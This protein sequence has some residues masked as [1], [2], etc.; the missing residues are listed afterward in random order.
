M[1]NYCPVFRILSER[2]QLQLVG[3]LVNA[4]NSSILLV[5]MALSA[6]AMKI[7]GAQLRQ[8]RGCSVALSLAFMNEF[9]TTASFMERLRGMERAEAEVILVW[10]CSS[11]TY[12]VKIIRRQL[13]LIFY[14]DILMRKIIVYFHLLVHLSQLSS[15]CI[16]YVVLLEI[17]GRSQEVRWLEEGRA[18]GCQANLGYLHERRLLKPRLL[19]ISYRTIII[20][21][22]ILINRINLKILIM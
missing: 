4:H 8:I 17:F 10:N 7:F 19:L 2:R 20:I 12:D 13:H 21:S 18:H 9:G 22:I 11:F 15:L 1:S 3:R 14:I 5:L 6:C 16:K